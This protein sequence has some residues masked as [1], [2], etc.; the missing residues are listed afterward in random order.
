[1]NIFPWKNE[2][3]RFNTEYRHLNRTPVGSTSLPYSVGNNGAVF[4]ANLMIWF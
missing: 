4:H 2:V 3:V 1:V